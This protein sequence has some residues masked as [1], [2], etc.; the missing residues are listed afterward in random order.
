MTLGFHFLLLA[1]GEILK[2]E[3]YCTAQN[4]QDYIQKDDAFGVR[5]P[6][7]D[8]RLALKLM[9]ASGFIVLC[10]DGKYCGDKHL[11]DWR[12]THEC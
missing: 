4:I 9:E 12:K 7:N 3:N 11:F 8:C 1:I 2:T 10:E 5:P 6:L